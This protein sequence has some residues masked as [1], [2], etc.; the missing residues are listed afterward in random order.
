[1]TR[2]RLPSGCADHTCG[3]GRRTPRCGPCAPRLAR[4]ARTAG[5]CGRQAGRQAGGR[6][7]RSRRLFGSVSGPSLSLRN[8]TAGFS[9]GSLSR[10]LAIS[11]ARYLARSLSRCLTIRLARSLSRSLAISLSHD[12]PRSLA[13]GLPVVHVPPPAAANERWA[14]ARVRARIRDGLE[15]VA[16]ADVRLALRRHVAA[17]PFPLRPFPTWAHS[18][19]GPF[20]LFP[21]S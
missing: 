15:A 18:H 9:P 10:S 16:A 11:L 17:R 8:N 12:P 14:A 20:Q 13:R 21:Q 7:R 5:S 3:P 2:H 6:L 1:V 19:L 4:A